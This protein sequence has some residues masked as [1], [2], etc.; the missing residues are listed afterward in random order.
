MSLITAY[1][2]KEAT[3][4]DTALPEVS[5]DTNGDASKVKCP[6]SVNH[7]VDLLLDEDSN[8][9]APIAPK[10]M[11][12]ALFTSH[13]ASVDLT[14]ECITNNEAEQSDKLQDELSVHE[15]ATMTTAITEDSRMQEQVT[16]QLS[17]QQSRQTTLKFENGKCVLVPMDPSAGIETASQESSQVD[18]TTEDEYRPKKQQAKRKKKSKWKNTND[19]DNFVKEVEPS[20]TKKRSRKAAKEAVKQLSQEAGPPQSCTL[21]KLTSEDDQVKLLPEILVVDSDNVEETVTALH[22]DGN[23]EETTIKSPTVVVENEMVMGD[24]SDSDVICLTPHSASP[25]SQESVE[26][27]RS[28]PSTPAKNKWSHIFGIKSPQKKSPSRKSSPCKGSPRKSNHAKQVAMALSSLTTSHEQYT[29]GIPLFHHIMQQ[30]NSLLWA[31]PKVELSNIN[32][33]L[34]TLSRSQPHTAGASQ[35]LSKRLI[36]SGSEVQRNSFH[37]KVI[38][39]IINFVYLILS[40]S[41][42]SKIQLFPGSKIQLFIVVLYSIPGYQYLFYHACPSDLSYR[43]V[44]NFHGSNFLWFGEPR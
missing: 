41:P 7:T 14:A 33:R 28:R 22:K 23:K 18:S 38:I 21:S 5:Q 31:L 8:L 15:G 27:P 25:L 10:R 17:K 4:V 37:L 20:V 39:L 6:E 32:A 42:P 40:I 44:G 2:K 26:Q 1:F 19:E 13:E 12:I 34:T 36:T 11:K 3:S 29:L 9:K 30:D 43:T 35:G 24:S 16:V